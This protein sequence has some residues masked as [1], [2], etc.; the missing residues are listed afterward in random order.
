M[1]ILCQLLVEKVLYSQW[2]QHTV[3]ISRPKEWYQAWK[4]M[5]IFFSHFVNSHGNILPFVLKLICWVLKFLINMLCFHV[6]CWSIVKTWLYNESSLINYDKYLV[7]FGFVLVS[8]NNG[9]MKPLFV[10]TKANYESVLR[11]SSCEYHANEGVLVK[12]VWEL[13]LSFF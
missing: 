7:T 1:F 8:R 12:W 13:P 11:E 5:E 6:D 3:E 4:T 9:T 10:C 2:N